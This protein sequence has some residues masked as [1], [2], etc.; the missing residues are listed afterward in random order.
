ME[1]LWHLAQ[2][3]LSDHLTD[4]ENLSIHEML[5]TVQY[6]KNAI[7]QHEGSPLDGIYYIKEGKIR[8]YH[9]DEK[10]DS[11]TLGILCK[12][13]S[14]GSSSHFSL[15]TENVGI[16]TLEPT[17]VSGYHSEQ[18]EIFLREKSN[19][20]KEIIK[21]TQD[22]KEAQKKIEENMLKMPIKERLLYWLEQ[23]AMVHG[24]PVGDYTTINLR[25]THK[26]LAQM[27]HAEEQEI[28]D[29][30]KLLSAEKAIV[31]GFMKISLLRKV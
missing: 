20:V 25:L 17:I 3:K 31:A 24:S 23:L 22:A 28:A 8:L 19:F 13:A 5:Q 27:I 30:L 9:I 10:G 11:I 16:E 18:F 7:I 6:P 29:N 15:A 26:D 12:D 21:I 4:D 14:F 2:V 1:N